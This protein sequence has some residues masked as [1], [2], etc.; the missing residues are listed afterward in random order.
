MEI[1]VE[2]GT[3]RQPQP[4]A[5]IEGPVSVQQELLKDLWDTTMAWGRGPQEPGGH[6]WVLGVIF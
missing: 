1:S 5:G 4:V 3:A 6:W 2:E